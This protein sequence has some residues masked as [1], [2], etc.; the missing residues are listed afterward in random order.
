LLKLR[1]VALSQSAKGTAE[2]FLLLSPGK[3]EQVRFIKGDD[4]LK[5]FTETL[6]KADL[7]MTFPPNTQV[8]AVRRAILHCGTSAPGPCTLEFIP[9]AV[10]RSLE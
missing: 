6:Q 4:E 3:V 2:F 8:Q 5:S 1:S 9:S 10:V 7:K